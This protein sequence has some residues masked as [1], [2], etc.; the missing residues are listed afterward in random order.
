MH[1]VLQGM[2]MVSPSACSSRDALL[3]LWLHEACRVF[4]DRL[5]NAAD[6]EYFKRMLVRPVSPRAPYPEELRAFTVTILVLRCHN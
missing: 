2:L 4:H 5:I 1:Q 3:R 6:R